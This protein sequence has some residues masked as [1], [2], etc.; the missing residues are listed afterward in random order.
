M[1]KIKTRTESDGS[2]SV[3]VGTRSRDVDKVSK[4]STCL[5]KE[6]A[7]RKS[8]NPARDSSTTSGKIGGFVSFAFLK[9]HF[10]L[11]WQERIRQRI[12][13]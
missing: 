6:G 5:L 2:P 12:L 10:H 13:L 11:A 8:A 3:E 4:S 9:L 7:V 1:S